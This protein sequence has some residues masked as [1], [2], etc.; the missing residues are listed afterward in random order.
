MIQDILTVMAVG[1]ASAYTIFSLIKV[2]ISAKQKKAH[3]AGCSACKPTSQI[4]KMDK[5][6][7]QSRKTF[8][9]LS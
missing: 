2:L 5:K 8:G 6:L 7:N 3:C 1:G 4:F 9:S